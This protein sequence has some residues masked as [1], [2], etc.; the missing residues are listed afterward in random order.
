MDFSVCSFDEPVA[1]PT[2]SLP[3]LPPINTIISHDY[4]CLRITFSAGAA[5]ITAPTSILLALK[6]G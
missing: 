3:V 6:P 5:P 1:P 4:G 2:P